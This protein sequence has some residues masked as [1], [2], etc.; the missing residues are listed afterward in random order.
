MIK[1][2]ELTTKGDNRGTFIKLLAENIKNAMNDYELNIT[3]DFSRMFIE[4]NVID[5]KFINKLKNVFGIHS[6]V[7]CK[8]I[9]SNDQD[10]IKKESLKIMQEESFAT[11][12]VETKRSN[13]K[14]S[15]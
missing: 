11:F 8:K 4:S 10:E 6:F 1:Y 15:N 13:K 12:K 2:G 7:I 9:D 5:D 14:I 3:Y